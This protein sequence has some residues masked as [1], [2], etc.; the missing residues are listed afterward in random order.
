MKAMSI[1]TG[2]FIQIPNSLE[3]ILEEL[4]LRRSIENLQ[5]IFAKSTEDSLG[6][7]GQ[8]SATGSL[9][10]PIKKKNDEV[11]SIKARKNRYTSSI[12]K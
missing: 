7:L 5:T 1:I 8:F 4:E 2:A 9:V 12:L 11:T 6:R 10:K 3:K